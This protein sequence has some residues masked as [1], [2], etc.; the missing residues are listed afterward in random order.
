MGVVFGRLL[1]FSIKK[2]TASG[3]GECDGYNIVKC[4]VS[5]IVSPVIC[6]KL[7]PK[8]RSYSVK[9]NWHTAKKDPYKQIVA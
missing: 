5:S 6:S 8:V 1:F 7:L 9:T 2:G 4:R 3:A